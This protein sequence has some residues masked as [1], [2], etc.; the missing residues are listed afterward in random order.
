M[1]WVA[2][3]GNWKKMNKE[4]EKDI[5]NTV[6]KIISRGDN[7]I[8]GGALG[9]DYVAIDETLKLDPTAKRIKIFLPVTLEI[10]AAHHRKRAKERV[11]TKKQAEA[12]I[13]QLSKVRGTNPSSLVEN[14]DNAIVNQEIYYARNSAVIEAAD[15]LIAFRVNE[16]PG[17][18]D[19]IEKAHQKDIPVKVFT[20]T[21]K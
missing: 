12:L 2:I 8:S 4:L 18:K 11:I 20:Y 14:K 21:I 17:T 1:K 19:T 16:S 10:Y 13:I 5:R 7:I 9:V 3:S 6:R 15:E